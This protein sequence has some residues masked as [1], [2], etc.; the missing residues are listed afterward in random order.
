MTRLAAITAC[1]LIC[2][3][4]GADDKP[5]AK[6]GID[7]YWLGTL[8]VGAV[9]LRLGFKFETKDGKLT[10]TLDSIDQGAKT[11]PSNRLSSPTTR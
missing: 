11:S 2:A 10:A 6:K 4:L 7:G 8:K 1:L 5:T 3:P 9:E